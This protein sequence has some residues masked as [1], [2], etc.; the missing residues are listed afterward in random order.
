MGLPRMREQQAEELNAPNLRIIGSAEAQLPY[1]CRERCEDRSLL[2]AAGWI[3][4]TVEEAKS[5]NE[6]H[7]RYNDQRIIRIPLMLKKAV[8]CEIEIRW[9]SG[10]PI[11]IGLI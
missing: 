6:F 11:E 1:F 7:G 4:N 9:A 2:C 10:N 8:E 5:V 3:L